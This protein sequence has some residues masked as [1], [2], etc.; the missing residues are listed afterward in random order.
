MVQAAPIHPHKH[1]RRQ[2]NF[3]PG[4]KDAS[5]NGSNT[6]DPTKIAI[7]LCSVIGFLV[8]TLTTLLIRYILVKRRIRAE[9]LR[10][11]KGKYPANDEEDDNIVYVVSS[12]AED[13]PS[14]LETSQAIAAAYAASVK[15]EM[16]EG[17]EEDGPV[18]PTE[19]ILNVIGLRRST[20]RS[21]KRQNSLNRIIP[22]REDPID[23]SSSSSS[24]SSSVVDGRGESVIGSLRDA[25]T[26]HQKRSRST[27]S[28]A[29]ASGIMA[30][31]NNSKGKASSSS[32][33][34]DHHPPRRHQSSG[35]MQRLHSQTSVSSNL[36]RKRNSTGAG[37]LYPS[38][39]STSRHDTGGKKSRARAASGS[40]R[41]SSRR[42]SSRPA[43]TRSSSSRHRGVGGGAG[44]DDDDQ[45]ASGKI[46]KF[47]Y[48]MTH[49]G[50][51]PHSTPTSQPKRK[52]QPPLNVLPPRNAG[53]SSRWSPPA[54]RGARFPVTIPHVPPLPIDLLDRR[55]HLRVQR[56]HDDED[57]DSLSRGRTGRPPRD[58]DSTLLLMEGEDE[59]PL[60]VGD[61]VI[62]YEWREDGWC[63]GRREDGSPGSL[64][65]AEDEVGPSDGWFPIVCVMPKSRRVR[66]KLEGVSSE[67]A[68]MWVMEQAYGRDLRVLEGGAGGGEVDGG[69]G[70]E[71]KKVIA[72]EVQVFVGM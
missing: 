63:F 27:S 72:P 50:A 31:R 13:Y 14:P 66:A 5:V 26:T 71:K 32:T 61:A 34:G 24:R 35:S 29:V 6:A 22:P 58:D 62:V 28:L 18:S 70:K 67:R 56:L 20:S 12:R 4:P 9:E 65:L 40:S 57:D 69:K 2:L 64:D 3:V 30:S 11:T 10:R 49:G 45:T 55:K 19:K 1:F 54:P 16:E 39:R 8:V 41:V 52:D 43:S 38:A 23:F 36:S 68:R 21:L 25:N 17:E 53:G 46:R 44:R 7:V 42:S 59:L 60:R 37:P 51:P 47:F 48:M 15:E 33:G